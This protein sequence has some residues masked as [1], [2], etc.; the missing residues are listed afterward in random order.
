MSLPD[1]FSRRKRAAIG[2]SDP[3]RYDNVPTKVRSQILHILEDAI[4][5][6][7]ISDD[8]GQVFESL[9]SFVRRETGVRQLNERHYRKDEFEDW[10]LK[11]KDLDAVLDSIEHIARM[12]LIMKGRMQ[13]REKSRLGEL[14]AELNGRMMEACVGYQVV[15][16][17]LIQADSQYLHKEAVVPALALLSDKSFANAN[18]EFLD[19]HEAFRKGDYDT[20]IVECCKAFEST[21]KV[22]ASEK[23]WAGFDT[24]PVKKL[25]QLAFDNEL[26][27]RFLETEFSGLRTILENGIGTV[28]NKAGGHG[29]GEK[30]SPATRPLA[31]FQLHQTAAAIVLLVEAAALS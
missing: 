3:L 19:A 5:E 12:I 26:I 9:V 10:F 8:E 24:A 14:L 22:I 15:Q 13:G 21:L 31:A 20:A 29:A 1:T 27:P 25:L 7:R 28:R 18:R 6:A 16:G 23:R 11:S 17:H 30:S 2:T 4:A